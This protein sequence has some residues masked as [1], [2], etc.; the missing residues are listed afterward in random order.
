MVDVNASGLRVH[1]AEIL[2]HGVTCRIK[3]YTASGANAGYDDDVVLSA[4]GTAVWATGLAL[5]VTGLKSSSEALLLQQ[6]RLLSADLK[7]FFA[8]T[9]SLSGA[10]VKVGVGSPAPIEHYVVPDGVTVFSVNNEA[11]YKKAYLRR[12]TTGSFIGEA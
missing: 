9:V 7:V 11:V 4:S 5:P 2:D 6:G 1:L 8:G 10:A 3:Q 12:L